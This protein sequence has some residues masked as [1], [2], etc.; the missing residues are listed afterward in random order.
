MITVFRNIKGLVNARAK[1]P[2]WV[3]GKE[4]DAIPIIENAWLAIKDKSILSYGTEGVDSPPHGNMIDLDGRFVFPAFVDAHTHI[5]YAGN[6]EGEFVDRVRGL[7]YEAIAA[8]GGGIL[9]SAARLADADEGALYDDAWQ[10]LDAICSMGTGA[11]EI[12]SGYG[13]TLDA[14]LKMLRVIS[15]LK[16]NHPLT[17]KSTFLGAHAIPLQYKSNPDAY[18]DL[19]I[20]EMLPRVVAEGLADFIDAFCEKNYFTVDQTRRILEAG[21]AV[22]LRAKVHVNQ[23][24]VLGAVPMCVSGGALSVDHLE[25]LEDSDIESLKGSQTISVALPVCSLYL[26][27]PFTPARK[28]ID[29]GLPLALATDFNPG[30]SPSGNMSLVNALACTQMGMTPDEAWNASTLNGAYAMDLSDE[31]GSITPG[32]KANLIVSKKINSIA[33]PMYHAAHDWIE[34]VWVEGGKTN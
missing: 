4:M 12:K 20:R 22:G 31:L 30:S 25:Y 11:V 33:T 10:R 1:A 13:L 8:K 21:A 3:A 28:I 24:N 29:A 19:I 34:Q 6:R 7:S 14:E 15:R 5:V 9:N 16:E 32:K 23:F 2:A 17:I 26:K 27:I 18:V